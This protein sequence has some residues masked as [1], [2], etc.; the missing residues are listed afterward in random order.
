MA[1]ECKWGKL[2]SAAGG[3]RCKKMP[4][5]YKSKYRGK[6]SITA[7]PG[8]GW[9]RGKPC[10]NGL[11]K[12]PVGKRRC[13]KRSSKAAAPKAAPR[14]HV[15]P[16]SRTAVLDA[17]ARAARSNSSYASYRRRRRR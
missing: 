14:K 12:N 5:R 4:A 3:R 15:W 7:G 10:K 2:K 9:G 13:K 6:Y 1:K 17:R 11:L 16:A 8:P